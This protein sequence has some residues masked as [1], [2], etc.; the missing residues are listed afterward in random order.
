MTVSSMIIHRLTSSTLSWTP[1]S[2]TSSLSPSTTRKDGITNTSGGSKNA[3]SV[4]GRNS[5]S[6]MILACSVSRRQPPP[7]LNLL[8]GNDITT[9]TT[10]LCQFRKGFFDHYKPKSLM[11]S[12]RRENCCLLLFFSCR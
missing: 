12:V 7:Q 3:I 2:S 9:T 8:L 10:T 1:S 4:D 5:S 11:T 6:P